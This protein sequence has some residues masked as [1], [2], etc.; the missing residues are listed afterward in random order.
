MRPHSGLVNRQGPRHVSG[1]PSRDRVYGRGSV[2]SPNLRMSE[3]ARSYGEEEDTVEEEA[4]V[5][6]ESVQKEEPVKEEDGSFE[7]GSFP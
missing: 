6:E 3:N 4:A 2:L 7:G 5:E 1:V